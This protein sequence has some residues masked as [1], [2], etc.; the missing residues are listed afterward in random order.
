LFAIDP[1]QRARRFQCRTDATAGGEAS[2]ALRPPWRA[3]RMAAGPPRHVPDVHGGGARAGRGGAG[4]D[5][6]GG[7]SCSVDQERHLRERCVCRCALSPARERALR[8]SP[9]VPMGEGAISGTPPHP[10]FMSELLRLPSPTRGE[11]AC[12]GVLARG[13]AKPPFS[14]MKRAIVSAPSPVCILAKTKGRLPRIFLASRSMTSNEAPT[15]GARSILLITSRSER[16][17]PGPPFD[18]IFSPAATSIT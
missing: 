3:R 1:R 11:G 4:D 2:R 8:D 18:G 14:S 9:S 13:Y 7:L 15:W 10:F 12:G 17:M 5:G 16:V 6:Q